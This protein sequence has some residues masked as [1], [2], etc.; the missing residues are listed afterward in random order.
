M[1]TQSIP[2]F[3]RQ[4]RPFALIACATAMLLP[5]LNAQM[6]EVPLP[7]DAP[8]DNCVLKPSTD[9]STLRTLTAP[10]TFVFACKRR[11]DHPGCYAEQAEVDP[12]ATHPTQIVATGPSQGRWTCAFF[13]GV[14]G[15]LPTGSLAPLPSQP[16][17]PLA[18]WTGWYRQGKHIAGMED[19]RLLI[20]PGKSPGTLHVS[21]RAFWYG[22]NDNVHF[23]EVDADAKPI[24]R[25]LH[26]VDGNDDEACVLDLVLDPAT[27]TLSANDNMN[28]GGMNVRF[29][30][31]W[32]RFVP[33]TTHKK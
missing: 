10:A 33:S 28:C 31:T 24:G 29:W 18:T 4:F 20:Q 22:I 3:T 27:R 15:W 23:G 30:G 16:A 11:D 2:S 26:V 9:P 25:F 19:D 32:H 8:T 7:T 1:P 5:A 13:D 6:H 12:K 14:P 21:G 17:A